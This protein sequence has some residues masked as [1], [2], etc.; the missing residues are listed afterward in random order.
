[1][2]LLSELNM[3]IGIYVGTRPELIKVFPLAV[4][5]NERNIEHRIFLSGQHAELVEVLADE[6]G[7]SV[8]KLTQTEEAIG[9]NYS[10]L[11]AVA[12]SHF[13]GPERPSVAIVHGD[14]ATAVVFGLAAK[15]ARVKVCHLEAGLRSGSLNSPFP[16][17]MN[18]KILATFSDLHLAPTNK[19]MKNLVDE[20]VCHN[21]IHVVG[22]TVVDAIRHAVSLKMDSNGVVGAT[23]QVVITLHR[24]ENIEGPLEEICLGVRRFA[25][26]NPDIR[27]V[28]PVHPNPA[29]RKV[30]YRVFDS[31][32]TVHLVEPLGY[33]DM[34]RLLK[35]SSLVLTDSGGIQEEASALNLPVVVARSE[36]ER[37]ELIEC[38]GG[39]LAGTSQMSVYRSLS[40]CLNDE[41]KLKK[42]AEAP[43]PFGDGRTSDKAVDLVLT[44]QKAGSEEGE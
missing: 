38:G 11:L 9:G 15:L 28:F 35:D 37:V 24:R 39:I 40:S 29:V 12:E 44:L 22:N 32:R 36:T 21:S 23:R 42:M 33:L 2:G 18:R 31:V 13:F 26:E 7:L 20:G 27:F 8:E 17:E 25:S 30:V 16:E 1:M 3:S 34:V 6:L 5:F 19:A 41:V 14:T 10:N 4:R 43:C